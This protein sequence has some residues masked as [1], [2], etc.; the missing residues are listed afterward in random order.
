MK[1][2]DYLLLSDMHGKKVRTLLNSMK[3][4]A[5][6]FNPTDGDTRHCPVLINASSQ[7]YLS[8][9]KSLLDSK[10]ITARFFKIEEF[11]VITGEEEYKPG[12]KL[13]EFVKERVDEELGGN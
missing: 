10:G 7:E 4:V 5:W 11:E 2:G 3:I 12:A 6:A 8:D 13:F 9:I 1:T